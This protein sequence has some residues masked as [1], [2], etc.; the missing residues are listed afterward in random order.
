[1]MDYS[2]FNRRFMYAP[3]FWI[4]HIKFEISAMLIVAGNKFLMK[5]QKIFL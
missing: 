2:V 3:H 1:M 5:R 4:A